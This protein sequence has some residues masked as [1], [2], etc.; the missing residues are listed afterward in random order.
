LLSSLAI[1]TLL[2]LSLMGFSYPGQNIL[3]AA[4]NQTAADAIDGAGD[5]D[6]NAQM[7]IARYYIDR[8][9][10]VGALNRL[11]VVLTKF[12][13]DQNIEEALAHLAAAYLALGAA[14]EASTAVAVLGRKFPN[15]RWF[16]V[17]DD[18]LTAAGLEATE[19]RMSWISRWAR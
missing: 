9:E 12:P 14:S 1:S 4:D 2:A 8:H 11:K 7:N 15:G 6:A 18:A 17:A 19:D 3:R 10:Y 16:A 13:S 5:H